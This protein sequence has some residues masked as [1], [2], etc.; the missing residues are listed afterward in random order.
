MN[1][2]LVAET[3]MADPQEL[4]DLDL[5]HLTGPED[6]AQLIAL[7]ESHINSP[8]LPM[9]AVE[10]M[11]VAAVPNGLDIVDDA[12]RRDDV[13]PQTFKQ[14]VP[15]R[16]QSKLGYFARSMV[17][18]G[19]FYLYVVKYYHVAESEPEASTV[20]HEPVFGTWDLNRQLNMMAPANGASVVDAVFAKAKRKAATR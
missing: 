12:L 16:L 5:D 1:L 7:L 11:V 6:I 4:S 14:W 19:L 17:L 18:L 2:H 20:P 13:T 10:D 3:K 15:S 9:Q 8:A